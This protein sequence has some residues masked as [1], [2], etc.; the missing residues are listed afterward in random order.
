MLGWWLCLFGYQ[1]VGFEGDGRGRPGVKR[2]RL[3]RHNLQR[4]TWINRQQNG[5][6]QPT[7][8]PLHRVRNR[9]AKGEQGMRN[10]HGM[11]QQ[12]RHK[13]ALALLLRTTRAARRTPQ[14]PADVINDFNHLARRSQLLRVEQPRYQEQ[15]VPVNCRRKIE[16]QRA[17][18]RHAPLEFVCHSRVQHTLQQQ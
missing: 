4:I 15:A 5:A 2:L 9:A 8:Q 13:A 18:P 16:G 11:Q 17:M 6:L 3:N 7:Q 10:T 1:R 14:L 12:C